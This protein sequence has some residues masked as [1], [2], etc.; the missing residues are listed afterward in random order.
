MKKDTGIS[1][2]WPGLSVCSVKQKHSILLKY[3]PVV[4]GVTLK[5]AEPVM[6]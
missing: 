3:A 4:S 6:A 1:T 5:T 2:V